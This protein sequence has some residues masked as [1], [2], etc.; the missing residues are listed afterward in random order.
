MSFESSPSIPPKDGRGTCARTSRVRCCSEPSAN[1]PGRP[2]RPPQA[3]FREAARRAIDAA[4]GDPGGRSKKI[5]T[6]QIKGSA[7]NWSP[8]RGRGIG[9]A[10]VLPPVARTMPFPLRSRSA[11]SQAGAWRLHADRGRMIRRAFS[12]HPLTDFL[13]ARQS[14][15]LRRRQQPPHRRARRDVKMPAAKVNARGCDQGCGSA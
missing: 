3:R 7:T 4:Q 11:S 15:H 12:T 5:M 6:S 10:C 9:P 8:A 1:Q 14:P 2:D 13:T